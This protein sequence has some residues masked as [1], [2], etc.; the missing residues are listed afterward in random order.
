[1]ETSKNRPIKSK[2]AC[3]LIIVQIEKPCRATQITIAEVQ[4]TLWI[5]LGNLEITRHVFTFAIRNLYV[6]K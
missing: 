3:I 5:Q 2:S 1:M 6:I 4:S